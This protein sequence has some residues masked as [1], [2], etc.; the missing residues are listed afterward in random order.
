VSTLE[1]GEAERNPQDASQRKLGEKSGVA[2]ARFPSPPTFPVAT[3]PQ[4]SAWL[5]GDI[6]TGAE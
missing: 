3:L 1:R 5:F 6:L 2:T 4:A